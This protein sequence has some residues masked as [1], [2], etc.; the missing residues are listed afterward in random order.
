M[1]NT[2]QISPREMLVNLCHFWHKVW[3]WNPKVKNYLYWTKW[4]IHVFDLQSSVRKLVDMLNQIAD[5]ASKWKIILFVSTKPQTV[6]L[7]QNIH[8]TTKMP[9]VSYKWFW[10]LLTNFSTIKQRIALMRSLKAQFESWEIEKYTKKEQSQY[11]K[12][13]E[14]LQKALWGLEWLNRLPD[15]LFVVDWKKDIISLKEARTLWITTLWIVDSNTDPDLYDFFV[16]WN[17]DAMKSLEFVLG[18]VEEAILENKK[19]KSVS[20]T[21]KEGEEKKPQAPAKDTKSRPAWWINKLKK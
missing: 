10:W 9:V 6:E 1:E 17:D 14:K 8:E 20:T 19:E 13:L 16:P 11:K 12:E 2:K 4:W 7:L 21:S 3:S 5:L 18:H 15:A